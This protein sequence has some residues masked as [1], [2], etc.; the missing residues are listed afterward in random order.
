[1]KELGTSDAVSKHVVACSMALDKTKAFGID[2]TNVFGF[3][4]TEGG[5]FSGCSTVGVLPLSLQYGFDTVRQF[6]DGA[7]AMDQHFAEA[8]MMQN[9]P[10]F[11]GLLTVWNATMLGYEGYAVWLVR[12]VEQW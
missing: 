4:E 8:P 7:H 9:L 5:R 6:L 11:M 12:F 10:T 3:W 1:M 2:D